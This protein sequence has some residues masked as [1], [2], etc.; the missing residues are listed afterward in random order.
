VDPSG[1]GYCDS[2][3]AEQG[4]FCNP[5]TTSHVTSNTVNS[6]IEIRD[7]LYNSYGN[8]YVDAHGK[9]NDV[10]LIALIIQEFANMRHNR[11]VFGESLEAVSNQYFSM[12][13]DYEYGC[14][15]NCDSIREQVD[16]MQD[17]QMLRDVGETSNKLF[18]SWTNN[19][20]DAKKAMDSG[21]IFGETRESWTWGNYNPG[22]HMDELVIQGVGKGTHYVIADA[23]NRYLVLTVKQN[24]EM[25]ANGWKG[26]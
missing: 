11:D 20:Q 24:Q 14:Y 2:D 26:W 19:I 8:K 13:I 18:D 22:S 9:I 16:W 3:Y 10:A 21:Y 4:I 23:K 6:F 7:E 25:N 15:G 5:S 1:H 12:N 17:I